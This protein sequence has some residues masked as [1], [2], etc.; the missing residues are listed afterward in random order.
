[1]LV[2]ERQ[3]TTIPGSRQRS[4]LQGEKDRSKKYLSLGEGENILLGPGACTETEKWS[5]TTGEGAGMQGLLEAEDGT[6]TLRN[7]FSTPGTTLRTGQQQP[8]TGGI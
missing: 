5:V 8:I 6:G 7:P 1:M 3:E 2:K 4:A